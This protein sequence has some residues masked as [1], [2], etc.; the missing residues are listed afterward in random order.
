MGEVTVLNKAT[1]KSKSLRTTVPTGIVRQFDLREG[2]RLRWEI[3]AQGGDL[4]IVVT[5][6]KGARNYG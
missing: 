5:P 2:D 3:K 4:V 1:P 6:L